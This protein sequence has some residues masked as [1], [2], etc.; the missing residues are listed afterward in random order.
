VEAATVVLPRALQPVE[1]GELVRL[2]ADRDGGYVVPRAAIGAADVLL[3]FG[4]SAN[5]EFEKAFLAARR[6]QGRELLI[7]AYDHTV[8]A[9]SLRVYRLKSLAHFL[10]TGRRDF[11]DAARRAG[12]YRAFFDGRRATHFKERVA[13]DSGPGRVSLD[14][15]MERI[16][17][18]MRAFLSMDIEGDEYRV[19][20]ALPKHA[21]RFGGIGVEFH[22]LDLQ[23]DRFIAIHEA[24]AASFVVAHVHINNVQGLGPGGRPILLEVT[25]LAR[26]LAP[27]AAI[28]STRQ[29]PLSGLDHANAADL[30]DFRLEF[31]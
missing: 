13:R 21:A 16:P 28:A 25:Y 24:L 14:A 8:D 11:W 20:D 5:W 27:G 23:W 10:R 31:A 19:G 15:I 29:Y 22:D 3:S 7:H 9:R 12:G 1:C 30:P 18:G 4:L 26:S 6:A 2:G 17:A